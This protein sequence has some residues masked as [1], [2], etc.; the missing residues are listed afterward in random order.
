MA[1]VFIDEARLT[2]IGDA[3]R[4]KTGE[5]ALLKVADMPAAIEGIVAG[6]GSDSGVPNPLVISGDGK[7][8]FYGGQWDWVIENFGNQIVTKDLET[9]DS[10][11]Y[12]SDVT[13]IPFDLN[14]CTGSNFWGNM[15]NAF[16]NCGN[17]KSI[18]NIVSDGAQL[19][20]AVYMQSMFYYCT[21]LRHA[22]E[23]VNFDWT[24]NQL[25]TPRYNN[26]FY[27][28]Q[29]LRSIPDSLLKN[30]YTTSKNSNAYSYTILN[31]G[32]CECMCL[33]EIKGLPLNTDKDYYQ[34]SNMF[35]GFGYCCRLKELTFATQENGTPY[36]LNWVNQYLDLT[37]YIGY[38]ITSF[39]P[40]YSNSGITTDKKVFDDAT[41]Q[42]L[43]NDP[44]WYTCDIAYSRYN[45]DS[46]VNTINT[47][48]YYNGA[49]YNGMGTI[50]FNGNAGSKT[51][52]GAI[53]TLT[54]EEIAVATAK[55][56][57]VAFA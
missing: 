55:G 46:A 23:F 31:N 1:T 15:N 20:A 22:P 32:F 29:S 28:C 47:L 50:K 36:S 14:L 51:D 57:T 41:Y 3:I 17:L 7:N 21:K 10:M 16:L 38:G 9:L 4:G 49:G 5:S 26:M 30:L 11:F 19:G 12:N 27:G 56:W 8:R 52:G 6:G 43:K 18:G 53:N 13:E 25:S 35:R 2:A 34:S 42:A 37:E 48:P 54:E 40:S 45:H 44:D 39:N 33:D 24:T